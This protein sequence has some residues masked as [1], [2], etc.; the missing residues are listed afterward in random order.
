M[1]HLVDG[2]VMLKL[3]L[4]NAAD[5]TIFVNCPTPS[6]GVTKWHKL[7]FSHLSRVVRTAIEG[8]VVDNCATYCACESVESL[9]SKLDSWVASKRE[10]DATFWEAKGRRCESEV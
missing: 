3:K 7:R 1:D 2:K 8:E 4:S 5:Y 6:K 9:R 10:E